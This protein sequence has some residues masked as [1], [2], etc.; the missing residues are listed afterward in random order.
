MTFIIVG[1][2]E[3]LA[4]HFTGRARICQL[5]RV[6]EVAGPE[7]EDTATPAILV[8]VLRTLLGLEE[9]QFEKPVFID[10]DG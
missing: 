9:R 7:F 10:T 3:E 8:F 2:D 4:E 5:H 1:V 6:L